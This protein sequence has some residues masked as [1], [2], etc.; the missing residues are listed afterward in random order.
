MGHETEPDPVAVNVGDLCRN[1]SKTRVQSTLDEL[2]AGQQ[3]RA[4]KEELGHGRFGDWINAH[5]PSLGFGQRTAQRLM[6]AYATWTSVLAPDYVLDTLQ[7]I[8]I[9]RTIWGNA[10][11]KG[12]PEPEG[13]QQQDQDD[14]DSSK[15]AAIIPPDTT[16]PEGKSVSAAVAKARKAASAAEGS[17]KAAEDED[18]IPE[19][20][21]Q[22]DVLPG[23]P[24]AVRRWLLEKAD[25]IED[26]HPSIKVTRA[27]C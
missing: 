20:C 23:T 16:K 10:D 2:K 21:F 22:V 6:K 4:K 18:P 24:I 7:A 19:K 1:A 12:R 13:V 8:E 3:L 26:H 17:A 15:P 25:E 11:M 5:K 27:P 14:E 9:S